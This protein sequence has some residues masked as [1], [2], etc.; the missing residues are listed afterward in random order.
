[1]KVLTLNQGLRVSAYFVVALLL[2]YFGGEFS[3]R[4]FSRPDS[5]LPLRWT[6]VAV[7][8]LSVIPWMLTVLW[9][10]MVGDEYVRRIALVGTAGAF[11]AGILVQVA[12]NLLQDAKIVSWSTHLAPLPVSMGVWIL[13]CGL[14]ALYYRYRV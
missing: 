7:G 6:A 8:T 1:L 2:L 10:V 5:S 11:V 9:S 3:Q 14:S 13:G 4:T 12:F